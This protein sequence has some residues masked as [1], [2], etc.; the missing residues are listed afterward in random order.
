M[1]KLVRDTLPYAKI[2]VL[3]LTIKLPWRDPANYRMPELPEIPMVRSWVGPW[4]RRINDL[5]VDVERTAKLAGEYDGPLGNTVRTKVW[6]GSVSGQPYNVL[7]GDEQ[8][9]DVL[10]ASKPIRLEGGKLVAPTEKIRLPDVI[11]RQGDPMGSSDMHCTIVDP[12][13]REVWDMILF[14][15]NLFGPK[16]KAGY[17]GG[18]NG[19]YHYDLSTG[20]A[21]QGGTCAAG[22]P[23]FPMIVG[24][25]EIS[26]GQIDHAIF[27]GVANY[28]PERPTGFARG[29]DGTWEGSPLRAGE[30]LRLRPELINRYPIGSPERTIARAMVDH[31][32]FIGDK[33]THG[34]PRGKGGSIS[35][36]GDRRFAQLTDMGLRLTDFEVVVQ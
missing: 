22:V 15:Q 13:H 6:E 27:V 20:Y 5:P 2:K 32:V 35:T 8:L 14:D 25:D 11:L 17:D 1:A 31:G 33:S 29:T 24:W 30:L 26:R 3:G 10:N 7:R 16:W 19:I 28:S 21:G 18:S 34:D 4:H 23:K 9:V 36:T 12:T